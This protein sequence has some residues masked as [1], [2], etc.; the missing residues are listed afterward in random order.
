MEPGFDKYAQHLIIGSRQLI[1]HVKKNILLCVSMV[2]QL[3]LTITLYE[4]LCKLSVGLTLATD[5]SDQAFS[6]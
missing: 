6:V 5:T 1:I 4:I 3:Y 2:S